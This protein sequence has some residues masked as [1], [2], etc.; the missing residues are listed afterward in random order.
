MGAIPTDADL[1]PPTTGPA[2]EGG[3]PADYALITGL[4][5]AGRSTAAAALEDAGWY[6]IDN[7]PSSLLTKVADVVGWPGSGQDRVALVIGRGGGQIEEALAAIDELRGR[8][9]R[10][11]V[12][13]LD[14]P[15]DILVRRFEGTRRRHPI[16]GANVE[17][18]IA[19]ER[20][21]LEPLRDRADV[22]VDTGQLNV[23]Q[24]RVRVLEL[25]ADETDP[26]MCT[27]VVSFG[28]K[29]G[30]PLDADLVFDCR[31]L[32]NP[33][34]VEDLQLLSG[35]D[36]PVR[37]FVLS[38]EATGP[39]LDRVVDLVDMLL[40][41]YTAEGKSYLT[42][43]MGCTGGRHRSVVLAAELARRLAKSGAAPSVFHRDVDR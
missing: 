10:V 17:E 2:P 39:F 42:I 32:P 5:G 37:E 25:F 38:Q 33:H 43:A 8:G 31:F 13:Y 14:A 3:P 12:V 22:V 20:R 7:M 4:S 1:D 41:A 35:L 26:A 19:D 36:E 16:A 24:L 11:R 28:Y 18:A 15:Q 29:H 40:P 27:S 30:V 9:H 21:L 23:N 34:W 6:V